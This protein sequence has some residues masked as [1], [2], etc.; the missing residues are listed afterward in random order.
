[1]HSCSFAWIFNSQLSLDFASSGLLLWCQQLAVHRNGCVPWTW[2]NWCSQ[3][4]YPSIL[5]LGPLFR[6][7]CSPLQGRNHGICI[8]PVNAFY[9]LYKSFKRFQRL[10]IDIHAQYTV[11]NYV[12]VYTAIQ[13][14]S[15]LL[16]GLCLPKEQPYQCPVSGLSMANGFDHSG[17]NAEQLPGHRFCQ[18]SCSNSSSWCRFEMAAGSG[19]FGWNAKASHW[20]L[21]GLLQFRNASLQERMAGSPGGS[22]NMAL[23]QNQDIFVGW[24]T[25]KVKLHDMV[26]GLQVLVV[27]HPHIYHADV[28]I[29]INSPVLKNKSSSSDLVQHVF[30]FL[31]KLRQRIAHSRGTLK[32]FTVTSIHAGRWSWRCWPRCFHCNCFQTQL[33]TRQQWLH[34]VRP[35]IG[36]QPW[37]L[38]WVLWYWCG[39][40]FF[41]FLH[42]VISRSVD[43]LSP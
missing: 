3:A 9:Q 12:Q 36:K 43:G 19:G 16:Q 31:L 42:L 18:L 2:P 32:S 23:G 1:M 33:P 8:F 20:G 11:Y 30:H 13:Y 29:N 26:L 22:K 5:S 35:V 6:V 4:R 28:S 21:L 25:W 34:V 10:S 17:A 14:Y 41:A 7:V 39:R 38:G 15:C 24:R 27:T 40:C 37:I